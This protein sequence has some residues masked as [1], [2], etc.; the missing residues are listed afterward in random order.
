MRATALPGT[1]VPRPVPS[2]P[3]RCTPAAANAPA[4]S[5]PYASDPDRWADA[6]VEPSVEDLLADP[7]TAL[8]MRRD[9]IG[10]DDV[11]AAVDH[12]RSA[13]H[14]KS[15]ASRHATEISED[16][17]VEG[18]SQDRQGM[19]PVGRPPMQWRPQVRRVVFNLTDL[20][21]AGSL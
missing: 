6:G 21:L 14:A 2:A 17:A 11:R 10:V 5:A 4:A 16:G 8:V 9:H 18:R 13:L 19:Q 1:S 20:P 15:A 3:S 12:A 7:L